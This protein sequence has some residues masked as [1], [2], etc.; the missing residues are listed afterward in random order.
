VINRWTKQYRLFK[1]SDSHRALDDI[2][3]SINELKFYKE[4]FFKLPG[5]L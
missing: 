4:N 3:E 5:E 1:K 2:K